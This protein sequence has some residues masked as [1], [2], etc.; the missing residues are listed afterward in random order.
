MAPAYSVFVNGLWFDHLNSADH[1][2]DRPEFFRQHEKS[3]WTIFQLLR[4]GGHQINIT[5]PTRQ[6]VAE[7]TEAAAF[8]AW[9]GQQYPGLAAQLARPAYTAFPH[10]QDALPPSCPR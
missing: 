1:Y 9:V 10:P 4:A 2:Q 6:V 5:N 7:F 3:L 8:A